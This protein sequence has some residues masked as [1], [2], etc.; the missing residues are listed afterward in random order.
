MSIKVA[1]VNRSKRLSDLEVIPAVAAL[2]IQ[3]SRDFGPIWGVDAH[4]GFVP[5]GEE[6]APDRW[7]QVLVDAPS[8][9]DALGY[10]DTTKSGLP[11]GFT[12][13]DQCLKY[14]DDWHTTLSHEMLELLADPFIFSVVSMGNGRYTWLEVC[15]AVE[16]YDYEIELDGGI[17]VKVSDF[18]TPAWFGAPRKPGGAF[19]FLNTVHSPFELAPG[20]YMGVLEA[21]G[22]YHQ[23]TRRV[24]PRIPAK[25]EEPIER[26]RRWRRLKRMGLSSGGAN[27]TA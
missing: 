13:L 5:K 15:D 18:Q 12:S 9:P 3:V 2:Q 8:E 26:G 24:G 14:G 27:S 16:A 6:A 25:R 17:H 4:V 22:S 21:D 19:S 7:Q 23:L 11:I 20:G 1:I 10:H